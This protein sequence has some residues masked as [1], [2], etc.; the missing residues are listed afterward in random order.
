AAQVVLAAGGWSAALPGLPPAALPPVRPVKG[1]I[2]RLRVGPALAPFLTHTVRATVR[3]S[4]VYLVPR[5]GG[6]LVVGSTVE[7]MGFDTTV[8]AG[9]VYELLRDAHEVVPAVTELA[10][11]ET[12]AGLRPGSPDNAPIIGPGALPGL[13]LATGHF[14]NGILLTPVTADAVAELLATGQTPAVITPFG[15]GRFRGRR[16]PEEV[17]A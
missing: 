8:T 6:E 12:L 1:Q 13:V 7:E 11:V 9:G 14:R 16:P 2:L 3:G 5:A 15:P 4:G 10:L 17:P